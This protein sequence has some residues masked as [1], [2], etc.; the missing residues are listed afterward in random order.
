MN[1]NKAEQE[2]RTDRKLEHEMYSA[3]TYYWTGVGFG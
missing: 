3:I 1:Q 2:N